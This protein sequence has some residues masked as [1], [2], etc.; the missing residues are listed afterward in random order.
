MQYFIHGSYINILQVPACR[1]R[2][3]GQRVVSW[4]VGQMAIPWAL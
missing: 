1:L 3:A 2:S 4:E